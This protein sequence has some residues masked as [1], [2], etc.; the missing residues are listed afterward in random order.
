MDKSCCF[1]VEVTEQDVAAFARLSGDLNPLHT[2]PDFARGTEYGRPIVH[3]AFLVGLVSRVLG[4]HI[5]GPR[6][7]ILSLKA[8]F[9]K[10]LYYPASVRVSGELTHLNEAQG[11]GSVA[12]TVTDLARQW[13]VLSSE[14]VFALHTSRQEDE[15][16]LE[17]RTGGRWQSAVSQPDERNS[18][19]G[20]AG[21]L[22]V[23]GGTG[24][25]GSQVVEDL[26]GRYRLHCLTRRAGIPA[27]PERVR[28]ERVDL[29]QPGALEGFLARTAPDQ[30]YGVLHMSV[31]PLIRG[32]ASDDLG[33]VSRHWRHAVEVPLLLA[34]W[35][36]R[37]GSR[38]KRMVLLGSTAGSRRP[39]PQFGAYSLG[40]AAMEHVARLLTA[41]LAAQGATVNVVVPT[42]VP[43]GLNEGMSERGRRAMTAKMPT[44]RL[45]EPQDVA[46][47]ISFLLSPRAS[48][49]NGVSIPVDGG[50]GE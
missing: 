47:I 10:P 16:A 28:Y 35:A 27:G 3:G 43:L 46:E 36:R 2:D 26:A 34:K 1:D 49:I 19:S 31:P 24:G 17:E 22:L 9:P 21:L 7:L 20:E 15:P 14:V 5:P 8:R 6:S 39:Q 42:M 38:V 11:V 33:E 12:V 45:I 40:K 44:G 48:Q 50:A 13:P 4:M 25:I 23:T 32:F 41:D 18:T 29:D 37:P 30:F